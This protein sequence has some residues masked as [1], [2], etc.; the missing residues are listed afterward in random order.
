MNKEAKLFSIPVLKASQNKLIKEI[1]L[2]ID[3]KWRKQFFTTLEQNYK[4][5]PYFYSIKMK[6]NA[7]VGDNSHL[8]NH[9][10]YKSNY[11]YFSPTFY[12][13]LNYYLL[14]EKLLCLK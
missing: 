13:E 10:L 5:A 14:M 8:I 1:E 3:D 11:T 4:K 9:I 6:W 7:T 12:T 2:G